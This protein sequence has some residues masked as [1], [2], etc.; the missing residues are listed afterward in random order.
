MGR[1]HLAEIDCPFRAA[2]AL[3]RELKADVTLVD[4]HAETTS[5][6]QAMGWYL[7]GRVS[8][9]FGTH[10]HVQT[11]DERVLPGGAAFISDAGMTGPRDGV[12]G[13]RREE[14][15]Q[16]FMTGL[17]VRYEPAEGAGQFCAALVDV[18][19]TAGKARGIK[20][21]FEVVA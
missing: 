15:I 14:A 19:E 1:H 3:L 20:R 7:D 11:A 18:D 8:A 4:M 16:R 13:V 21:I 2:D 10:T 5:E 9:V 12:I 6:R 17:I